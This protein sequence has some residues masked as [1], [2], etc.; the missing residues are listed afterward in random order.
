MADTVDAG[1]AGFFG[2]ATNR[3]EADAQSKAAQQTQEAAQDRADAQRW[4]QLEDLC[5]NSQ[6]TALTEAMEAL[7]AKNGMSF[8]VSVNKSGGRKSAGNPSLGIDI[9]YK[10]TTRNYDESSAPR[11]SKEKEN[12]VTIRVE[13]ESQIRCVRRDQIVRDKHTGDMKHPVQVC[14]N[15]EQVKEQLGDWFASVAPDRIEELK[16]QMA[17]TARVQ[18]QKSTPGMNR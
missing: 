14:T 9:E 11:V 16:Q 6:F 15:M 1:L 3:A 13:G 7:P 18:S 4:T 17:A 2:K 5:R 8:S 12:A 10:K